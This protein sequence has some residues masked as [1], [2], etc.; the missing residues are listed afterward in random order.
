MAITDKILLNTDVLLHAADSTSRLHQQAYAVREM[1]VLG[2][3]KACV[4]NNVLCE[5]LIAFTSNFHVRNPLS[6]SDAIGEYEKYVNLKSI[7]KIRQLP[8]TFRTLN[9]LV[10]EYG[11]KGSDIKLAEHIAT[12]IDN[13]VHI[14]CTFRE[15]EYEKFKEINVLN[16]FEFDN[17]QTLIQFG[18]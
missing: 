17:R 5:L 7:T 10:K 18:E 3:I 8:E 16:P 13:R 4:S 12:M 1:A 9:L 2:D 6:V 14:I 15:E 11:L